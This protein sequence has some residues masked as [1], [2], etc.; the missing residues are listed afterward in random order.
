MTSPSSVHVPVLQREVIEYLSPLPGQV[1]VDGTLGG[2]GHTQEIAARVIPGGMVIALDADPSAVARFLEQKLD[3]PIKV[4]CGNFRNLRTILDEIEIASVDALLLDVGLSSDQLASQAR[5][6]SFDALG[7]LDL[8][9]NENEGEPAWR[10]LQRI[11]E[12]ELADLIYKYGEERFS[13]RIARAIVAGREKQPIK[14]AQGLAEIVRRVV[15]RGRG[16]SR[17]DPA[18]RTF[19]A[20]RIAINDE[21]G[22]LDEILQSAP[23]CIR[24][25]GRICII[26]F[27][28][29]ED[30]LVKRAFR[31]NPHYE[32]LTKKP[33]TPTDEEIDNNPRC[34]S[35]KL[36]AAVI[37]G[38]RP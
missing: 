7:S 14:D 6:F 21:L 1:I 34:R 12:R 35:A 28:S 27:H 9:F 22:A 8:R 13:R 5:G 38:E 37:R 30:R 17:I 32:A 11:G 20:L 23:Q 10:L 15:P 3:L 24:P 36:R 16:P 18:T 4:L 2:G 33:I 29:L 26:S 31:E 25:G 19:Q